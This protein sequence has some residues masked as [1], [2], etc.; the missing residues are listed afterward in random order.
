MRYRSNL[1][2]PKPSSK[3]NQEQVLPTLYLKPGT[4]IELAEESEYLYLLHPDHDYG[5]SIFPLNATR[6]I[7]AIEPLEIEPI[8]LTAI[9]RA[10]IPII[11]FSQTGEF[12]GRI[13]PD[14][15]ARGDILKA[16]A[17]MSEQQATA[18]MQACCWGN[19]RRCRRYLLRSAREKNREINSVGDALNELINLVYRQESVSSLQGLLGM[20]MKIYYEAFPICLNQDWQF[21]SRHDNS[22]ISRMLNFSYKLLE[23]SAKTAVYAVGLNPA[24]GF[25][26]TTHH[27]Q[28]GLVADIASEFKLYSEAVVVRVV[29]KGQVLPKDFADCWREEK[30]PKIAV[31]AIAKSFEQKMNERFTYPHTNLKC[32]Y[33]ELLYLQAKQIAW[34]LCNEVSEY[35]SPDLR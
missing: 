9:L 11:I 30:L 25:W 4:K 22:P 24:I 23:Q 17:I 16:Q 27:S 7:L 13:E 21:T 32:S 15:P 33:Q 8:T 35:Y 14:Y 2:V 10:R 31:A 1:N 5:Q 34:Y 26:H 6:A 28:Q 20:G 3:L 12:L 18:I 29:N 19:L